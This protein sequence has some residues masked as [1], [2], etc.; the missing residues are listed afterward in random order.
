MATHAHRP[1]ALDC[2]FERAVAEAFECYPLA[3]EELT[4][5]EELR[6]AADQWLETVNPATFSIA[7]FYAATSTRRQELANQIFELLIEPRQ[8][9]AVCS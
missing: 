2:S 7:N 5:H 6:N 4:G 1:S 9:Y 8:R 3:R